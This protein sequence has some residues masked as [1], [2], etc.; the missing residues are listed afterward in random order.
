[1]K[2]A[3]HNRAK[4]YSVDWINYCIQYGIEFKVVNCYDNDIIS[5]IKDCDALMWHHYHLSP[6]DTLF[7]KQ[8]TYSLEMSGKI[9]FPDFRTSWH[10]DDKLGQKYLLE[11]INAPLAVSYA[12]YSKPEAKNWAEEASFPK[13]F[14]LRGGSS[15][16]NVK[17]VK[18]LREAKKFINK[19]FNGGFKQYNS[20]DNLKERLR[21]YRA[22]YVNSWEV[23]KGLTRI[24]IPTPYSRVRG[25]DR[26]YIYFQDF[27]P[28]NTHDIRVTYVFNKCFAS[29]RKIRYGDFRASGSGMSDFDMSQI[30][31]K[32][33]RIA[34]DVANKCKLQSAAFDF[35]VLNGEPLIVEMS[36]AFGHHPDQFNH[37]YWD[38][39][40]N[41]FKGTF[42]P[43]GWMVE[44]VLESIRRNKK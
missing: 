43:Y 44:G 1:M 32:A 22:D 40:L 27:V 8:L 28:D 6:R 2:I 7:A 21:K 29:R 3:I 9:V 18:N 4:S 35:V 17:L 39:N 13:V 25:K 31:T 16:D 20:T 15:S 26:G 11:S 14:K 24:I 19:A 42:D 33:L 41:Y 12:F 10:F 23:I 5:Q 30:P 34:F 37:G 38:E 36:Y